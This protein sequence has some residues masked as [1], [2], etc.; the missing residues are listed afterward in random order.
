MSIKNRREKRKLSGMEWSVVRKPM[1]DWAKDE[2][3]REK[4]QANGRNSLS[5]A[6]L[7]AIVLRTGTRDMSALQLA[8]MILEKVDHDLTS[9]ARKS[10]N[11]LQQF[12]GIGVA[13][14]SEIA[15][16][17]ELVRRKQNSKT[18][19]KPKISCS[20]DAYRYAQNYFYDLNHEEFYALYL[21]R[22]NKILKAVQISKGGISGTVADGKLIFN[23]ALE[24]KASG[25]ILVHNHPSGNAEPSASDIQLTSSLKK[26]GAYIEVQIL[27][28]LILTGDN[29]FSFA[30]EGRL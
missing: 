28:H 7:L 24:L 12:P 8:Q 27:D 10:L 2:Q 9:L 17:M 30:D 11:E 20:N 13:K 6:E 1:K 25:I 26:F 29:Y 14:A 15:A 22:A 23:H 5:N 19:S 3:P 4:M 21:N 18:V 16:V